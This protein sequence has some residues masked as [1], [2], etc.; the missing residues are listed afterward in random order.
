MKGHSEETS[1]RTLFQ[2]LKKQKQI[3]SYCLPEKLKAKLFPIM[4]DEYDLSN[5][6]P[7]DLSPFML[8]C[9]QNK[10]IYPEESNLIDC[11]SDC[12]DFLRSTELPIQGVKMKEANEE[13]FILNISYKEG[14][15]QNTGEAYELIEVLLGKVEDV[16]WQRSCFTTIDKLNVNLR[17]FKKQFLIGKTTANV[18]LFIQYESGKT[19]PLLFKEPITFG[20]PIFDTFI[21]GNKFLKEMAM[22]TCDLPFTWNEIF[23]GYNK[24]DFFQKKYPNQVFKKNTNKYSAGC[25]Y[26]LMKIKPF[27]SDN[28]FRKFE[29]FCFAKRLGS[30]VF[31]VA[32]NN[33][34]IAHLLLNYWK[35]KLKLD[36]EK[37]EDLYY[38]ILDIIRMS[39]KLK[40]PVE[41]NVRSLNG[42]FGYHDDLVRKLNQKRI[43]KMNKKYIF[44]ES[45]KPLIEHLGNLKGYTII[46]DELMLYDE[47][48]EMQHCVYSYHDEIVNG[49]CLIYQYKNKRDRYTIEITI[50]NKKYFVAQVYGKCNSAPSRELIQKI[51]LDIAKVKFSKR[52][53]IYI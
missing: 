48:L 53:K 47:G 6:L 30:D 40:E 18:G 38:Y 35:W 36:E 19:I 23:K 12:M 41:L 42:L 28:A 33:D 3:A 22:E 43:K 51:N 2:L 1:L 26:A 29:A 39:K 8:L 49:D 21:E 16:K 25:I 27:L 15:S 50:R 45:F 4:C 9:D 46:Q 13:Q 37:E 7:D 17:A 5:N 24:L 44:T 14:I 34:F 52:T 31:C 11:L 10:F 20:Y 32:K